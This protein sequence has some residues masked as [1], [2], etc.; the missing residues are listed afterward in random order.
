MG[1]MTPM[2]LAVKPRWAELILSGAKTAEIRRRMPRDGAAGRVA[3]LYATS[4]VSAVVG[5]V[6]FEATISGHRDDVWALL[7]AEGGAPCMTRAECREYTRGAKRVHALL[8]DRCIAHRH[9]RVL[10]SVPRDWRWLTDGEQADI[11]RW[12]QA[13]LL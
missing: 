5:Q 10:G 3:A 7:M 13:P 8:I 12:V 11:R 4:P 1:G 9:L 2:L 6:R